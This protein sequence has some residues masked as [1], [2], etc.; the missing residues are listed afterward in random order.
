M[1]VKP[2]QSVSG[3]RLLGYGV[4][5][6]GVGGL[7]SW[8]CLIWFV[9][10]V[11]GAPLKEVGKADVVVAL[12]GSPDRTVYAQT[13][14]AQ[15]LAPDSMSTLFDPSC[16]RAQGSRSTCATGVRNTI[17]EAM[18]LRRIFARERFTKVI[19]VTSRYHL[20]RA[21]VV[22]NIIF[23]GGDT[24]VHI[25]SP[26]GELPNDPRIRREALSYFPSL[27]GAVMGHM[28]PAFYEG[29]MRNRPVRPDLAVHPIE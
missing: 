9:A 16:L 1:P 5:L 15:G 3:W 29:L 24:A 12:A 14:V 17:D 23:A 26:P 21:K 18:A 11:E 10:Y 6:A 2:I 7:L 27:L 25:V 19:V 28:A 13:L 20:A 22:F 4:G 8:I